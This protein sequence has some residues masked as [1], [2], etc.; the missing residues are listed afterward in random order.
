MQNIFNHNASTYLLS[1]MCIDL[2]NLNSKILTDAPNFEEFFTKLIDK[3]ISLNIPNNYLDINNLDMM[4]KYDKIINSSL[5]EL[6]E[7][8]DIKEYSK[9]YFIFDVLRHS[10]LVFKRS[11]LLGLWKGREAESW[12]PKII[13]KKTLEPNNIHLLDSE[14]IIFRGTSKEEYESKNFNQSWTLDIE[15][16]KKFAFAHYTGQKNHINTLRVILKTL[17]KRKYIY[18]YSKETYEKEIIVNA[19]KLD[20]NTVVILKEQ[21][22]Q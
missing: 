18:Y 12:Y 22:M 7:Q 3:A 16:A 5:I 11:G 1:N 2:E 8:Y 6:S 17:I 15:V 9:E 21:L 4:N 10:F 19:K 13:I 14:I 20:F